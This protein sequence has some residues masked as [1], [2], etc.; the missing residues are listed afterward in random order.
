MSQMTKL[1]YLLVLAGLTLGAVFWVAFKRRWRAWLPDRMVKS[2]ASNDDGVDTPGRPQRLSD[3]NVQFTVYRPQEIAP[4]SW[5]SFLAFAHLAQRPPDALPDDPDPR[6]VV[7]AQAG[8]LLGHSTANYSPLVQ[9][10]TQA[11]PRESELTFMPEL[12]GVEFDP[13][14]RT[15]YWCQSVHREAFLL[16]A[17]PGVA[18]RLLRGRLSVFWGRLLLAD[19]PLSIRV[20]A[21]A[22]A[23][24]AQTLAPPATLFVADSAPRYRRIFAS[25]SHKDSW[26]VEEFERYAQVLG[27]EYLRDVVSLR[28]GESW[29]A[30]LME[31]IDGADV[32]QLFWSSTSIDSPFVRRE[33]EHA[34]QLSRPGFVRPVYWEDPLP[35]RPENDL[36]PA[37][38]SQ[39]HFQRLPPGI[40]SHGTR[41]VLTDEFDRLVDRGAHVPDQR[42]ATC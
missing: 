12:E 41:S 32:F 31:L 25:Y 42:R 9:D 1:L 19:V 28:T 3:E 2:A 8:A 16:R 35:S 7:R 37:A 26:I 39:L 40:V 24:A 33:W 15:F 22:A 36:P 13:P 4:G 30:R 14:Q 5:Y 38:L 27:D 29:N 6:E 11:V 34:L 21:T 10:A 18:G 17:K 20:S 23:S